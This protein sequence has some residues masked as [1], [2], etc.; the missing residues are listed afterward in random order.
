MKII[1]LFLLLLSLTACERQSSPMLQA[2]EVLHDFTFVGSGEAKL[3]DG[4]QIDTSYI[5]PHGFK[6]LPRPDKLKP[7]TQYV[8]HYSGDLDNRRLGIVE[9]PSRLNKSGFKVI[10]APTLQGGFS[11]PSFSGPLFH[12]KFSDGQHI[13]YIY[14]RVDNWLN[15]SEAFR[16]Q[17]YIIV[18]IN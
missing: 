10:E 2:L 6:Q 12:I 1:L 7:I 11:Y 8:F 14:N 18:F 15:G 16:N 13:G 5:V 4:S 17:D 3:V 9:L